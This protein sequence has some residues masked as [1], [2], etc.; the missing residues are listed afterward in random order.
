MP[1][2]TPAAPAYASSALEAVSCTS[3]TFCVAFTVDGAQSPA[4]ALTAGTGSLALKQ[5]STVTGTGLPR[6]LA[7][8]ADVKGATAEI[9]SASSTAA[10]SNATVTS[11]RRPPATTNC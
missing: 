8:R 6:T 2:G 9:W 7:E 5:S 10:L 11:T 1:S 4:T 3:L